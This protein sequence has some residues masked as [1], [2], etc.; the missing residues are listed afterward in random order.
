[1][2]NKKEQKYDKQSRQE[3]IKYLIKEIEKRHPDPYRNVSKERFLR[4]LQ[5]SLSV[6][7]EFFGI[8]IQESLALMKDAH[9][10]VQNIINDN[11]LP[12][13][14]TYLADSYCY[15]LGTSCNYVNSI[16]AKVEKINEYSLREVNKKLKR[17][18]SQE[19]DE[20]LLKDLCFFYTGNN[21]LKYYGFSSSNKVTLTTDKGV[22]TY[23]AGEEIT[24]IKKNPFKWK[25]KDFWGN[26]NYKFKV[27]RNTLI[28]QY[29]SCELGN[30]SKEQLIE[31]KNQLISKTQKIKY[32]V[33]DLRQNGGGDTEIMWDAFKNFPK[34]IP[35]YVATSR[36]TFS[37]AMH[38]LIY[39]KTKKRAIQIGENAGQKPNRFGQ[40][41]EIVLPN[42]KLVV[43]RSV[44]DFQL[45]PG[46]KLKVLKPDIQLPL[47][48]KDYI[49]EEDPLEEWIEKNLN[50]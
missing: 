50:N 8:A 18:S 16:G 31:F 23:P 42:S 9:T 5:K 43:H 33:V 47:T 49:N 12:I 37:S 30:F 19:N 39:L 32:I 46:S 41:E 35:I 25:T 20:Q 2:T 6:R 7:P 22:F 44:K 48:I 1:M 15:I 10:K 13:D 21:I 26:E 24:S 4:S 40:G 38:H 28:F 27:S 36:A 29:N 14:L 11:W 3:D 45:I 17:L 34:D